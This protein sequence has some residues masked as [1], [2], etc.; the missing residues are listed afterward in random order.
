MANIIFSDPVKRKELEAI[1]HPIIHDLLEK[2]LVELG[3][4]KK[5]RFWF[6]EATLLFET[7]FA[8]NF[9]QVWAVHCPANLQLSRLVRRDKKP[10]EMAEK[11]IK[12]QWSGRDKTAD[13]AV[14][15]DSSSGIEE[16]HAK[17]RVALE[18]LPAI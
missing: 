1:I 14:V 18:H 8:R 3:L 11:I 13:A 4:T 10:R 7:G 16:L 2:K 6:Y 15:I 17:I 12:S 9:R 5:P